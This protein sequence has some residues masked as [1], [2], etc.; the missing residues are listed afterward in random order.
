VGYVSYIH[1]NI[2]GAPQSEECMLD[3]F[4]QPESTVPRS[5]PRSNGTY[6]SPSEIDSRS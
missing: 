5:G 4:T 2:E 6:L 1:T 3:G